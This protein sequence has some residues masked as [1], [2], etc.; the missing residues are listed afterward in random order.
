MVSITLSFKPRQV[1]KRL[2][3]PL[4]ER[5]REVLFSRFG[6]GDDAERKTLEAIGDLYGITRERVRQIESFAMQTIKK[7][8]IYQEEQTSFSELKDA[9]IRLGGVL[10]EEDLLN[11]L[12]KD[13]LTQN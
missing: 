1:T 10:A 6:L 12:A 11:H 7:S 9:V 2:V 13:K 4:P 5:A 8:P 3:T